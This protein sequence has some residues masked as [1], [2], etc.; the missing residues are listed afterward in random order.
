MNVVL[1]LTEAAVEFLWWVGWGLQSRFRVQ[2]NHCVEVVLRCVV[3]GVVTNCS[4]IAFLTSYKSTPVHLDPATSFQ[5]KSLHVL[6]KKQII[7][8]STV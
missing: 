1:R 6:T 5:P 2:P 3:V 4:Y 7:F 8:V